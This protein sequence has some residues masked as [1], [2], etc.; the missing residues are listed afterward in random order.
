ML[1]KEFWLYFIGLFIVQNQQYQS[2]GVRVKR[3]GFFVQRCD[4]KEE[5]YGFSVFFPY[6][7]SHIFAMKPAPELR[8]VVRNGL[9]IMVNNE[10]V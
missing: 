7:G 1:N 6:P 2:Y 4:T 5:I 3:K 10:A 9:V 8:G